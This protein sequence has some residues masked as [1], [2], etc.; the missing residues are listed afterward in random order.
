MCSN[1]CYSLIIG[2]FT[3]ITL[4]TSGQAIDIEKAKTYF[5]E[6][7][8][9][10]EKDGGHLWGINLFGPL[11]FVDSET[12]EGVANLPVPAEDWEE[13]NGIYKGYMPD[14]IGFANT[15]FGWKG[16]E[17]SMVI[18]SSLTEDPFERGSLMMHE[19]WHQHEDKLGLLSAYE[20]SNHLDKKM[21]RVLLFLEWNAL[22]EASQLNDKER[23][24]TIEDALSFRKTRSELYP[25]GFADET[26]NEL[27]EGLAEY[28]GMTLSGW[29]KKGKVKFLRSRVDSHENDNTISWTYAYTSGVL[30]GFLLDEQSPG[31]NRKLTK[32]S[33]LGEVI[34]KEYKVDYLAI[35]ENQ[36]STIGKPYGYDT[37]MPAE[38]ERVAIAKALQESYK[39]RFE[40]NPTLLLP[41]FGLGIQ[42]NP[43][44][45]SPFENVGNV[46][47]ELSGQSDWGEIKVNEGGILLLQGWKGLVL[48]V[49]VDWNSEKSLITDRY[50][51]VLAEG[52]EI[53]KTENGWTIKKE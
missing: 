8:E 25:G 12:R 44:K 46:Y 18:F 1:K 37:I 5:K 31:W 32:G 45:I 19:L 24:K 13:V 43:S 2:F 23:A 51:L 26:A 52:Y 33:D 50:E 16:E 9:L 27:H 14:N 40:D 41:N 29:D 47:G 21:G 28:T 34:S 53:V 22:L 10:S 39:L 48:D 3:L 36:L 6:V 11:V 38:E 15:A 49:G 30:Y 42:F 35:N 7:K 17:W 4:Q 20:L